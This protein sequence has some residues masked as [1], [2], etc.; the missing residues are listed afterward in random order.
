MADIDENIPRTYGEDYPD[1]CSGEYPDYG[2]DVVYVDFNHALWKMNVMARKW[3]QCHY[4]EALLCFYE[5]QGWYVQPQPDD[6]GV[7]IELSKDHEGPDKYPCRA[8]YTVMQH[9]GAGY[10]NMKTIFVYFSDV[11]MSKIYVDEHDSPF[12]ETNMSSAWPICAAWQALEMLRIHM[13]DENYFTEGWVTDRMGLDRAEAVYQFGNLGNLHTVGANT[14]RVDVPAGY[15]SAIPHVPYPGI[16]DIPQLEPTPSPEPEPQPKPKK[17]G[18]FDLN[19]D[20]KVKFME[21][22]NMSGWSK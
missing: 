2:D 16:D 9:I 19:G 11:E 10:S 1:D 21:Y 12:L 3:C 13:N 6:G 18:K 20:G 22:Y 8:T 14:L 7:T 17:A 5:F 15:D 4:P